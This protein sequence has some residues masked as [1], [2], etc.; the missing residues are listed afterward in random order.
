MLQIVRKM[1][2]YDAMEAI[3]V[4][5]KPKRDISCHCGY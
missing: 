4:N 2:G 3:H 1:K 5:C